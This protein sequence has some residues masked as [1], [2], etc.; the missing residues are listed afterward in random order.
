MSDLLS[1]VDTAGSGGYILAKGF[2][3]IPNID[4]Q[5]QKLH[6]IP[7]KDSPDS[8]IPDAGPARYTMASP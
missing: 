1:F 7:T 5:P 2:S 6:P 3:P 4:L 8:V